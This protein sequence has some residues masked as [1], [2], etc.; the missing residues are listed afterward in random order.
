MLTF[1]PFVHDEY[2]DPVYCS[3]YKDVYSWRLG[4]IEY[5]D[6]DTIVILVTA[7]S[8]RRSCYDS[9]L[10]KMI[11]NEIHIDQFFGHVDIHHTGP[12]VNLNSPEFQDFY[13]SYGKVKSV[14]GNLPHSLIQSCNAVM[15]LL[16][17]RRKKFCLD[18]VDCVRIEI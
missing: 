11:K 8:I 10:D 2:R 15:E 7:D 12:T 14:P 18:K 6:P 17:V 13:I 5:D 16:F 3:I 1:F 4:R 9:A